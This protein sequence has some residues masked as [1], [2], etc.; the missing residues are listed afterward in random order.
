MCDSDDVSIVV[1]YWS[2][3]AFPRLS[4]TFQRWSTLDPLDSFDSLDLGLRSRLLR[5][6]D[7]RIDK[8]RSFAQDNFIFCCFSCFRVRSSF[9]YGRQS[10][11]FQLCVDFSRR[12]K[13]SIRNRLIWFDWHCWNWT[14]GLVSIHSKMSP[15]FESEHSQTIR[16]QVNATSH[17]HF[18]CGQTF[19]AIS[20]PF[21]KKV[22]FRALSSTIANSC[23]SPKKK[24]LSGKRRNWLVNQVGRCVASADAEFVVSSH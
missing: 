18:R 8:F 19:K 4:V 23:V 5:S 11:K 21:I 24:S 1:R 2:T 20:F 3:Q 10:T 6:L 13:E 15:S 16:K 12:E 17:A 14:S 22:V 7:Y 9:L